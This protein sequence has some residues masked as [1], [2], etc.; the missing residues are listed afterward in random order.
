M[1]IFGLMLILCVVGPAVIVDRIA[2][3]VGNKIIAQSEIDQ[4]IR[5]TAFE[6]GEKPDFSLSSRRQ[7]AQ[8][9]IDQ[10]LIEREMEVG[11]YPLLDEDRKKELL[12]EF[13][14]ANYKSDSAALDAALAAVGLA[15]ADLAGDLAWQS[16]LL[17]FL[18]LRFRPAVQVT[19]QDI[20]KYFSEKIKTGN[21]DEVRSQI[22]Q[23]LT[24]ER[25][26]KELDAWLRDQRKTGKIEYPEKDLAESTK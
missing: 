21:L 5:L 8:R 26:D 14:K 25:A 23:Q 10:K 17:T 11:H 7:A 12:T 2:V 13:A 22:E 16:D 6:N 18:S 3:I 20:Q 15:P 1:R 9:L 24:I 4:R 19:D